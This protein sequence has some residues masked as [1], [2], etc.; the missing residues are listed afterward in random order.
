MTY[1]VLGTSSIRFFSGF[2]ASIFLPLLRVALVLIPKSIP[3]ELSV[4]GH[5]IA[6]R[7]F[8]LHSTC[9]PRFTLFR[10]KDRDPDDTACPAAKMFKMRVYV[11]VMV[12]SAFRTVPFSNI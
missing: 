11:P 3:T 12:T 2:G 1:L 5:S 6:V 4:L 9:P 7:G 10:H 8:L